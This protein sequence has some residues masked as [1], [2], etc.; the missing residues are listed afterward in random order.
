MGGYL[1]II[2]IILAIFLLVL[3]LLQSKGSGLN[4]SAANDSNKIFSS[5]RGFELRLFQFTIVFAVIF[6]LVALTNSLAPQ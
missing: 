4:S 5:R 1:N 3:I 2:Q 6:M